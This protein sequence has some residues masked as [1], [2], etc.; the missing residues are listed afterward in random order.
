MI[1]W[2]GAVVSDNAVFSF[3]ATAQLA[4]ELPGGHM[5]LSWGLEGL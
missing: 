4:G 3:F 5:A 2:L 1:L